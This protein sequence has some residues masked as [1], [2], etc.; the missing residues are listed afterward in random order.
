M[1]QIK[2]LKRMAGPDGNY[3]PGHVM[4]IAADIGQ[5]LVDQDAAEWLPP[6]RQQPIERAVKAPV[7]KGVAEPVPSEGI[8]K[9]V[10]AEP[11]PIKDI[12]ET[13][14]TESK[15]KKKAVKKQG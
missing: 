4:E 11:E 14:K 3:S 2:L 13:A 15:P 1:P 9:E 6:V 5:Q 7:E 10:K 12:E 8:E